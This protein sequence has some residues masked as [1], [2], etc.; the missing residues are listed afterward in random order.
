MELFEKEAG[1]GVVYDARGKPIADIGMEDEEERIM[2]GIQK[3]MDDAG[4]T[5]VITMCPNCYA[6]LKPRLTIRVV[7]IYQKLKELHLG[8]KCLT[9]G[10]MFRPCPDREKG[11][12]I[13]D[14]EAFSDAG[15]SDIGGYPVLWPWRTGL[16]Q[17]TG[18]SKKLC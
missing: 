3:R 2:Q 14:I 12:W 4:V 6:F 13:T 7:N 1:I 15:I 17:R 16:R 9:G 5:E 8:E 18:D 11:E 10:T